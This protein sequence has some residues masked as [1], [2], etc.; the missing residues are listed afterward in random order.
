MLSSSELTEKI[1]EKAKSLGASVAGAASVE[2]LKES[3]SHRIC[4]KIGL[5]LDMHLPDPKDYVKPDEV[6]WPADAVSA[7]VIG[8]AH[9]ADEPELDWW[10]GRGTPGNRI[11]MQINKRLSEWI[12]NTFPVKTYQLPYFVE[13]GGIFL[14]DAAVIAGLGCIGKNNLVITP[15][16]GPRIRFRTLLLDQEVKATDPLEFNP[17]E[18]CSQPCRKACPQKAFQNTVYSAD[19]M[20]QSILPGINGTYDRVTCNVKMQKDI[21]EAVMVIPAGDEKH[22]DIRLTINEFEE[23]I[24]VKPGRY[25]GLY[26]VRYCRR[27][28]L[29]C[30]IGKQAGVPD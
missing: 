1:I 2:S 21:G 3:P 8:I 24:M 22:Q 9:N 18:D 4:P 6:F 11:L 23:D 20:G 16:Y 28:E 5:N 15:E 14:K 19:A 13:K 25:K 29:S 26:C 10:D 12:E 27:C 30:P 17:C 7:V